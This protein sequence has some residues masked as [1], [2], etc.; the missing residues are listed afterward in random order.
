MRAPAPSPL[1]SP[2]PDLHRS[3]LMRGAL[4]R[5]VFVGLLLAALWIAVLWATA[6]P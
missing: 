5:I 4:E 2:G 3:P 1:P 6:K